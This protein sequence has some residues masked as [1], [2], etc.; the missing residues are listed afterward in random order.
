MQTVEALKHSKEIPCIQHN[1]FPVLWVT[2]KIYSVLKCGIA[3]CGFAPQ[4]TSLI[5]LLDGALTLFK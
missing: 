4:R 2:L 3:V 1:C 5:F